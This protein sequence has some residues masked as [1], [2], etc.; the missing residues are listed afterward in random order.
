MKKS[1]LFLLFGALFVAAVSMLISC[2]SKKEVKK[3]GTYELTEADGKYGLKDSTGHMV[4]AP[5]FDEIID[6]AEYTAVFAKK[7]NLTTVVARSYEA[8]TAEIDSIVP[9]ET[10]NYVYVYGKDG[11]RLWAL[12]SSS[13]IGPF[14]DL[15]LIDGIAFLN[16]DGKWGAATIDHQ[17]LA[18]RQYEKVYVVKNGDALAVLVK[19]AKGWAMFNNEGVSGGARYD[20]SS[21]ILEK[22][23]KE[24]KIKGDIAVINVNWKL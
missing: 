5:E 18:P 9:S 3:V 17:A 1:V 13:V 11:V 23:I 12:G 2:N 24:L 22:Q 6:K 7:G 8:F 10:D 14:T 21:K 4:L 19:D 16:T 15:R 20:T